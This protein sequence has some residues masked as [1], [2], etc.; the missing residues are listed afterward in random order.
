MVKEYSERVPMESIPMMESVA[1]AQGP[2]T[3]YRRTM[4]EEEQTE[5]KKVDVLAG[6]GNLDPLCFELIV[7]GAEDCS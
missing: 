6:L 3:Q 4:E 5:S 7:T 1:R 2:V